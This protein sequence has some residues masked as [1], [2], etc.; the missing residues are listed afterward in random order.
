MEKILVNLDGVSHGDPGESAIGAV[1][2]DDIGNVVEEVS[3]RIGRTTDQVAKYRAL[4][5]AC[6]VASQYSPRRVIFFT[7]S[8]MVANQVNG[9]ARVLQPHLENLN[10]IALD[11]LHRLPEWNVRHVDRSVNWHAHRLAEKA[12]SGS[13]SVV[14]KVP[15]DAYYDELRKKLDMLSKKDQKKLLE[16][17][18]HLLQRAQR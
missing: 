8:Q 7:D 6:K 14:A 10:H 12:L 16:F 11:L 5:E 4:I 13:V 3:E 17:A 9:Q 18:N 1:L 15:K 2:V